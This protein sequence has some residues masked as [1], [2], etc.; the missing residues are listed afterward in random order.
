MFANRPDKLDWSKSFM[1]S[2]HETYFLVE[3]RLEHCLTENGGITFSQFLI[4]LPLH[5]G[6]EVSQSDVATFLHLTE[7]TVSRHITTMARDGLLTKKEV[8]GNRRKHTL[9]F[10]P[11]G[12]AAFKKAHTIIEN[13]LKEI[14]AIIPEKDR[15]KISHTFDTVLTTLIN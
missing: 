13:E 15:S 14:F 1:Y 3:K 10:T 4:F 8:T 12:S 9:T 11:K 2:L 7:A 5:C 6:D